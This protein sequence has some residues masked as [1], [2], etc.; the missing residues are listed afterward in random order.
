[1]LGEKVFYITPSFIPTLNGEPA[2]ITHKKNKKK[3]TM[4]K[5][6]FCN[7]NTY[8]LEKL[9]RSQ[10]KWREISIGFLRKLFH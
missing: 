1:M 8:K 3:M 10:L 7:N 4:I 9:M 6:A 2:H 5:G